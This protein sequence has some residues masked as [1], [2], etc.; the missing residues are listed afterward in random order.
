M[1]GARSEEVEE[2]V[3]ALARFPT[4]KMERVVLHRLAVADFTKHFKVVLGFL[5]ETVALEL[6]ALFGKPLAALVEFLLNGLQCR[7]EPFGAGH[8]EFLRVNPRFLERV[9]RL[10]RDRV[11]NLDALDAVKVEHDAKRVVATRHPDVDHFPSHSAL[12]ALQVRG[13]PAVLEFDQFTQE[14][15]GLDRLT[16]M[17]TQMVFEERLGRVETVNARY[18]RH[19]DAVGT[20]DQGSHGGKP[21]LFNALVDAQLLVDVQVPLGEVGFRL[22]VVV[23]RD[24]VLH[25]VIG[26]IA[27]HFLVQLASK[28]L[29]VAHDECGD[30][31]LFNHVSHG[32]RLA[33][34]RHAEQHAPLLAIFQ[35]RNQ[36]FN[37]FWL[38]T[39]RI[40]LSVESKPLDIGT[41]FL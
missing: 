31:E 3:R 27:H 33:A 40:E 7:L 24:E 4:V 2:A 26:E 37:C 18:R 20:G 5:L 38:V 15:T 23:V 10:P 28:G 16:N 8:E 13:R 39:G 36:F 9:K 34:A 11:T 14:V 41:Q 22:I 1:I 30:V 12:A 32:E 17:A 6:L 21:F 19:H 35:L 29:V 25:G